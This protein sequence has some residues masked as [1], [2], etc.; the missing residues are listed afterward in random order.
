MAR[1]GIEFK[2]VERVARQLLSQ[3]QHPSVQ[4]VRDVLGTGSNTTIA[5][6]LK[7]WQK[8]FSQSQSPTLPEAVPDDLMVPLDDF[9]NTAV[10]RAESNYQKLKEEL[11]S[12]VATAELNQIKIASLLEEKSSESEVLQQNLSD[13]KNTLY[14][15]E[16]QL[17]TLQGKYSALSGE[18]NHAHSE[19]EATLG[20]LKN[21]NV[22]F[23]NERNKINITTE[24]TLQ[25]ERERSNEI[26]NSLLNE[27]DQLRQA[28]KSI[29]VI[30]KS[31]QKELQKVKE[32]KHQH[33]LVL[34]QEIT[35]LKN[36]NNQLIVEQQQYFQN[37]K[38][39]KQ[40]LNIHQE[41]E[42]K[43]LDTI[44][45]LR[46][47]YEGSK[48]NELALLDNIGQLKETNA[49]LQLKRGNGDEQANQD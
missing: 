12:K 27:V 42:T 31:Q 25:Y 6:H 26:E 28:V 15:I 10:A 44:E 2:A 18:L 4:R 40:Q 37:N 33:E 48:N 3:G 17:N 35:D 11:E 23:E 14:K 9:W 19:V 24:Q 16:Q 21:Q 29:K 20:I 39:L 32:N 7:A 47:S 45:S 8:A 38:E 5:K 34:V 36:N 43:F 13:T 49:H 30:G 1:P 22:N 46:Q 41:Q